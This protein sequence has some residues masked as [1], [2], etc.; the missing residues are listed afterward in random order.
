QRLRPEI[1]G[2]RAADYRTRLAGIG[3]RAP[4]AL[5][6][7]AN[8]AELKA[9]PL[10]ARLQPAFQRRLLDKRRELDG[11]SKLL[12]TLSYRRILDRGFALVADSDGNIV[13]SPQAVNP[14][15]GLVVTVAEGRID[16][17]VSGAPSAPKRKPRADG[18]EQESLF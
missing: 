6:N 14:G 3:A 2:K 17:T 15:E 5:G 18:G 7:L 13:T 9:R 10:I 4:I 8:R 16:A 1:L 12:E 11:V